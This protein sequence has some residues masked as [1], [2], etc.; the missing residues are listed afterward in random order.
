MLET[1]TSSSVVFKSLG[2]LT[3]SLWGQ[4]DAK[5][6]ADNMVPFKIDSYVLK[7]ML[8]AIKWYKV[9]KPTYE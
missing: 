5:K 7:C 1:F 2:G 8:K 4:T 9:Q 3:H 6:R